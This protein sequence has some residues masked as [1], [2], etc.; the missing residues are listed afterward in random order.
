MN[1]HIIGYII[2]YLYI[3]LQPHGSDDS[4]DS[5]SSQSDFGGLN[6][7]SDSSSDA[8]GQDDRGGAR[9]RGRGRGRGRAAGPGR[10]A[11]RVCGRGRSQGRG[12]GG[13]RGGRV[14]PADL[15]TEPG[16]RRMEEIDPPTVHPFGEPSGPTDPL[17][18]DARP[19][20]F[21][22]KMFDVDFFGKLATATN[23]NAAAKRPPL[24]PTDDVN[25]TSDPHWQATTA[26]EMK[27]FVGLN[28]AMGIKDM[29]E[30]KDYWSEEPILHDAF[31]SGLMSRRR[32]EKLVEYFHCSIA[33]EEN[34]GDKLAKVRPLITLCDG[35]FVE[36]FAP[37]RD[38]SV[39]EAMIRFDGWLAW[40]QYMPKKPVKWGMKL[41]CLC[42][43]NTG[44]CLEFSVYTGSSEIAGANLDLGNRVVMS[45]MR[46]HL[47]SYHHLYA[48]N[49]FTSVHLAVDLK[50]ADT[51]LCGT[52]RSSRREFPKT[53]AAV[54]LQLG[55]SV[56][57]VN[58]DSVM[59]CKWHDKRDVF[60]IATNDAGE[61]SIRHVRRN[62]QQ[63][64]LTVPT[65][66]KIYNKHMG[67]VDHLDQM[68][69]YYGVGRAGRKWWK[70][71]FWGILNVGIINAYILWMAAN[72]PLPA[73]TR[74]FSLKTF[75]LKLIHDLCDGSDARVQRMPAAVDNLQVQY[76]VCD[77]I[78]DGHPLVRFVGRKRMCN[79][80]SREKRRTSHGSYVETSF[81]CSRCKVYLC[82]SGVC[83][84]RYHN[85]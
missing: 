84:R 49:F 58:D 47:H 12:R 2:I 66:V 25:A 39:D 43:A 63:I 71:L 22:E 56:K 83:F 37:S 23:S 77:D 52:T 42:D 82:K 64:D 70:Y 74:L 36:C 80:C 65:C 68:R 61:D 62:R 15:V 6:E 34:A 73:N 45:L 41:W 76:V 78:R 16:W 19:I 27:S 8:G 14:L 81:G 4:D 54:H 57:W 51:Y 28:I 67:G 48:D 3:Y 32:Y 1:I 85:V 69:A 18:H 24:Q 55:Q 35:K 38:L 75:K 59:L 44:Y 50:Q 79:L 60:I 33:T 9:G 40:K 29:P 46:R 72:R 5:E 26:S 17:P 13:A 53:L 11:G 20:K 10:A 21:F 30:Y 31:I 7:S